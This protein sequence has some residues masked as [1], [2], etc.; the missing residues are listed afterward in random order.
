[1]WIDRYV[2]RSV[3]AFLN[4]H[5]EWKTKRLTFFFRKKVFLFDFVF[6]FF[7]WEMMIVMFRAFVFDLKL[8]MISQAWRI[9][10]YMIAIA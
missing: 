6:F 9:F 4:G 8:T 7:G 5:R 10:I 1:M 2:V 3:E